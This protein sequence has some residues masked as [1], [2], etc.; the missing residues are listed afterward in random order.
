ML[1]SLSLVLDCSLLRGSLCDYQ[2]FALALPPVQDIITV[3]GRIT[4]DS[5]PQ[6]FA[7]VGNLIYS[8]GVIHEDEMIRAQGALSLL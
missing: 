7:L 4:L 1:C 6:V 8:D 2:V 3:Y 5:T